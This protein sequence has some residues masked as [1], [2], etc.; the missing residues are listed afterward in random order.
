M[1]NFCLSFFFII[2]AQKAF[3]F[4]ANYSWAKPEEAIVDH[5][6]LD[7][8]IDFEK[9]IV[10][11]S[12]SLSII[13]LSGSEIFLDIEG[14]NIRGILGNVLSWEEVIA[15]RG[16]EKIAG[17]KIN[18]DPTIPIDSHHV[19]IFYES[20]PQARGL[21]W[22]NK[23]QGHSKEAMLF[24]HNY[25]I[26]ARTWIP[27]QD[28]PAVRQSISAKLQIV[29]VEKPYLA[30]MSAAQNYRVARDDMMY[31]NLIVQKAIY[32]HQFAIAAGNFI[33]KEIFP[34]LGFYTEQ[35]W[36]SWNEEEFREQVKDYYNF[37]SDHLGR[38]SWARTDLLLLASGFPYAYEAYPMLFFINKVRVDDARHELAR[39]FASRWAGDSIKFQTWAD[40]G[41]R[42]AL[43]AYFSHKS[44]AH[45]HGKNFAEALSYFGQ[46]SLK[47]AITVQRKSLPN[48][49]GNQL[50]RLC[51]N[52]TESIHPD[53]IIDT[54]L[55]AKGLLFFRALEQKLG[56]EYLLNAFSPANF[57]YENPK[58]AFID[59][60]SQDGETLLSHDDWLTWLNEPG[61]GPPSLGE[62][63]RPQCYMCRE[64]Y[65]EFKERGFDVDFASWSHYQIIFL[66]KKLIKYRDK[67]AVSNILNESFLARSDVDDF[68]YSLRY[69]LIIIADYFD[70]YRPELN[71]YLSMVFEPRFIMPLYALLAQTKEGKELAREIFLKHENNYFSM[72]SE[73]ISLLLWP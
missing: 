25:P 29:G 58:E 19:K 14:L 49:V 30:L 35:A 21:V 43:S 23:G 16:D 50:T 18:L 32:M 38:S 22:V 4:L 55:E 47:R 57:T 73:K 52:T 33:H 64:K 51:K 2:F 62:Q 20:S 13:S 56:F 69:Q 37:F 39:S 68:I 15:Y 7:L 67:E 34:D 8:V 12:A 48:S 31:D 17:I 1:K 72:V 44:I 53:L 10:K 5:I 66:L 6:Y 54:S 71:E 63:F 45:V 41:L 65:L 61:Y 3:S 70:E 36:F 46:E 11:G 9:K 26:G 28:T 42:S 59:M 60:A 27:C 40:H 24:S